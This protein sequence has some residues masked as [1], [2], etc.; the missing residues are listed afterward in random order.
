MIFALDASASM[1][2]G[3]G[4]ITK[5]DYAPSPRRLAGL[6]VAAAGRPGRP[7]DLRRSDLSTWS[8]P[9]PGTSSCCCT[10]WA[11]PAPAGSGPFRADA[12][13]RR[14]PRWPGRESWWWS[15]TATRIPRWCSTGLGGL[16]GRGHDVVV[17]HVHRS[18]RAGP[19]RTT[20]RAPSRTPRSGERLP[21]RPEVLRPG[22][23]GKMVEAHRREL[24]RAPGAGPGRLCRSSRPTQ[25]LDVAAARVSRE[26]AGDEPGAI[27]GP[28]LPRSRSSS[29]GS[30]RSRSRSCSICGTGNG[31][32]R[33]GSPR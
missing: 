27:N 19:P 2:Y 28:R 24:A 32:V 9:R 14:P 4:P 20:R 29:P 11:E 18:R 16:R 13:A 33:T 17:F 10:P 7:G 26:P 12:G 25:P 6:A 8:R 30:R 23:P 21:L 5:F 1:D 3:T 15:P 31:S 22:I